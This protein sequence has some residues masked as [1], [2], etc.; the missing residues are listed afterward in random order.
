MRSDLTSIEKFRFL[1]E[2]GMAD[3]TYLIPYQGDE[4]MLQCMV[5][6]LH[7]FDRVSVTAKVDRP[8]RNKGVMFR[9]PT[10]KELRAVRNIFF[11]REE[12]V[13]QRIDPDP[14]MKSKSIQMFQAQDVPMP[15]FG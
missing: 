10:M 5:S 11:E 6:E 7:G 8:M 15:E 1:G 14:K 12:T 4:I 9:E 2:E 13:F 3:G